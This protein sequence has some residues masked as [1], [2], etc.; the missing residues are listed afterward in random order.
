[1]LT[2]IFSSRRPSQPLGQAFSRTE[3]MLGLVALV[4]CV[5]L[6]A[7]EFR[8][9]FASPYLA[10]TGTGQLEDAIL[11]RPQDIPVL[12]RYGRDPNRLSSGMSPLEFA[13]R[14]QRI[15]STAILLENGADPNRASPMGQLPLEFV[16]QFSS[17]PQQLATAS[18]LLKAGADPNRSQ[19][20]KTTP[21]NLVCHRSHDPNLINLLLD[22]G[23]D[24]TL[25]DE[26][27]R[28]ALHEAA[29][30]VNDATVQR[31]LDLGADPLALDHQGDAPF[32]SAGSGR[33]QMLLE[34]VARQG[35]L[36][37]T[38]PGFLS[39]KQWTHLTELAAT[40]QV[41]QKLNVIGDRP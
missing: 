32:R 28:T 18:L 19:S 16:C 34:Y 6:A 41:D 27:G 30:R 15:P 20:G 8:Y 1:M 37:E 13:I 22:Y 36:P 31:L 33:Q 17:G 9:R 25:A 29:A 40:G 26:R 11:H 3:W 38:K 14:F 23:A 2:E 5:G 7:L 21:L 12:V 10:G 39:T 24:P 4:V 35:R